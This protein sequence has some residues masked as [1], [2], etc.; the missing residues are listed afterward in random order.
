MVTRYK[1]KNCFFSEIARLQKNFNNFEMPVFTEPV[2]KNMIMK[3][4]FTCL[5]MLFLMF[6]FPVVFGQNTEWPVSSQESKPWTRWWWMENAVDK[7]NIT[8]E[9][10]EMADAGIGGVEITPIYGVKGEEARFIEFLSPEFSEML[11]FTIEE[12]NRLGMGVD[13]PPGSGW[14]CGGP[15]VPE[16]K[17]LWSL[18]MQKIPAKKGETWQLPFDIKNVAA[19]SFVDENQNIK[20]IKAD[21]KFMVPENGTIYLAQ[22]IKNSDKVKRPSKGGE[23]WAVDTF[24]EI[25]TNWYLEEFW[26]RLGIEE[27]KLR[28][29]FHDSFEYTGD[30]TTDFTQ[31]FKKRRGYDLAEYL[32]VLAGDCKNKEI[33]ARVY[34]DYRETLSDLVLESFIQP[35]TIWANS[36]KSLNRNQAHGS[37]GNILDLYAASDIPETEIFRTVEPG[38]MDVFV[39]KFASSAAH[40]TGKKLVSSESYTWLEEH[41]TVT[42][43]DMVRATNRFFLAGINHMFFHG[44]CYSPKDAQWPGWVFY[45][46]TQINNRNPLW[47]ELPTLFNYIQRSQTIL[48]QSKPENDLLIYW[49]YYDVAAS[50]GRLFNHLGVNKDAGW[51]INHPISGL[52]KELTKAGYSFDYISDRQ[53]LNCQMLNGEIV[54]EGKAKYKAVVIPK[55]RYIPVET[56]NQLAQFVAAG[57]KVYFDEYLPKSVPG[58][59]NLKEREEKLAEIKSEFSAQKWVGNVIDKLMSAQI[60]GEKSL[61]EKGFHYQKMKLDNET[62][63]MVFNTSTTMKDEWI[64]LATPAK[65]YVFFNPMNGEIMGC[66][67][68]KNKIRLQLEPEQSMFIK[69]AEMKTEIPLFRYENT[70]ETPFEIGSLWRIAFMNGGPAYPGNLQT[71]E[72]LS[73]TKMGD[74]ETRRF[75]GTVR[76]QTEFNWKSNSEC[77]ILDLGTVKDCAHVNLNG[78]SIGT[79]L[80]PTYKIRV[81]NLVQGKNI[82]QVEVTNVAANRIRD[83]DING[84]E[85]RRFYDINLVNIDYKPFDASGW[86]IRDAGLMGPVTLRGF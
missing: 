73:W 41:W 74:M 66:E 47:P 28:C 84:V 72:L 58:I 50:E 43:S 16:E 65:S 1:K 55:T 85:W 54:T 39:N 7:E 71:D 56:L 23:G 45:A 48:Q 20:I 75:A 33:V 34:S 6:N 79:L 57:G 46:S 52:S 76:Y 10:E 80:G 8:R 38:T 59:F 17:G 44:T 12:A 64:E 19:I 15:F 2:N 4:K 82:L 31:E 32:Y 37:P 27:G 53:L 3:L 5:L 24:N 69:C 51:F 21:E 13:L 81:D 60:T 63:Y 14:R 49:P 83:M 86:E 26:K 70:T 62:W 25:I 11:K 78:K 35:M 18:K 36:H 29:F 9:L 30:F 68:D 67:S 61:S 22:R 42:T 40:V 77:G